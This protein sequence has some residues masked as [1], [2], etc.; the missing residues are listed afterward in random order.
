MHEFFGIVKLG[1]ALYGNNIVNSFLNSFYV[2]L[3]K[4]FANNFIQ[5]KEL[6]RIYC[7]CILNSP[8]GKTPSRILNFLDFDIYEV[9]ILIFPT[10]QRKTP[11]AFK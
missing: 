7:D 3:T 6:D 1:F 8:T 9:M 10:N 11:F 2:C 4:I 5:Q